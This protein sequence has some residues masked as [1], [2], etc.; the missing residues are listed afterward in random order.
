MLSRPLGSPRMNRSTPMYSGHWSL[1]ASFVLCDIFSAFSS[2]LLFY[3][4]IPF[5]VKKSV[6]ISRIVSEIHINETP[7][8]PSVETHSGS[9]VNSNPQFFNNAQ[10]GESAATAFCISFVAVILSTKQVLNILNIFHRT[11]INTAS[12]RIFL[13]R[14][15]ARDERRKIYR[16]V[17]NEKWG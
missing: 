3:G 17:A 5:R 6:Q 4:G 11:H 13:S 15:R 7:D 8:S 16:T 2:R 10:R 9:H 14:R 1:V 12:E